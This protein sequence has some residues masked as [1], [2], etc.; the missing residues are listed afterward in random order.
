VEVR[1]PSYL[2][3]LLDWRKWRITYNGGEYFRKLYLTKF[4]RREDD[5]EFNERL[6]MTPIPAFARLAIN[7]VRNAIFQRM[8]DITR[9]GGTTSYQEAVAGLNLGVDKRGLNMNAFLGIKV[10]T[11]LLIMGRVG[12]FVDAPALTGEVT[13]AEAQ[14]REQRPYVYFYPIEDILSWTCSKPEEPTEF[15][16]I[17]LR[18]VVLNFDQR[19]YLPTTT[20]ERFRMLWIN[21]ETGFVNLQ[22]LDTDGNPVDRDGNPGGVIELELRRIP[23]ILLDIGDSMIKD[24]VNHQIALLNLGSSDVNYA[25]K[26][27]FPFYVEQRD[28]RASGAHLKPAATDGTAT[29]GGQPSA[30]VDIEVGP[31]HGRSYDKG[32]NAPSFIAPPSDPLRTSMELQDRLADD[33]RKLVNLAVASLASRQSAESKIVDNQGLEAGLSYIGLVLENAERQ[34]AE[35]WA[36]YEERNPANRQVATIKYPD[37]YSLK[38]DADRVT[39]AQNLVKLMTAVPGRKI[40]RELAKCVVTALLGGK[41]SVADLE[42]IYEEIDACPYTTSDVNTIIQAVVNGLCGEK[43]GS[44]ALGFDDDEHIQAAKDHAA[45]A[46][47]VLQAQQK[48]AGKGAGGAVPGVAGTDPA[49]RGLPD[50]SADPN[51][52]PVEEKTISQDPTLA[53]DH[54]PRVRG[55]GKN[56]Q[57]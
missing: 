32:L 21:R 2:S 7:D 19:T 54:Q 38:S 25:L 39:E 5:Q 30:D 37:V 3:S 9:R 57:E 15:Q 52:A 41:V 51:T 45:R 26:A 13:L 14:S 12:I 35:H 11:D 55:K 53:D 10:L 49:A 6:N 33:I 56:N 48:V 34:I 8:R 18:D 36:A 50:L 16:A 28:L 29:T 31:T 27:N 17:L 20:V 46:I 4:S 47:R 22:F 24:V 23:F 1:H 43:V 42:A 44:M 40:K